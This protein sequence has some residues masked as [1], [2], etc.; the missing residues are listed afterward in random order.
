MLK[1]NKEIIKN[2]LECELE[3]VYGEKYEDKYILIFKE[4]LSYGYDEDNKITCSVNIKDSVNGIGATLKTRIRKPYLNDR[5]NL[6]SGTYKRRAFD[7][8]IPFILNKEELESLKT[9]TVRWEV[10]DGYTHDIEKLEIVYNIENVKFKDNKRFY[11][12]S[13]TNTINHKRNIRKNISLEPHSY[14][15][16]MLFLEDR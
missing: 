7:F 3:R 1:E 13:N 2:Q 14:P 8:G 4:I 11:V 5:L 12:I 9:I 15:K 16:N 6:L 10:F